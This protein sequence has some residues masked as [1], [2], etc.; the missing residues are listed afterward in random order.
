[1]VGYSS[2]YSA[3][4]QGG[5]AIQFVTHGF[6]VPIVSGT[7]LLYLTNS[8]VVFE[9]GVKTCTDLNVLRK[10]GHILHSR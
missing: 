10:A 4:S 6:Y 9:E 2:A 3:L 1:M 5:S 8:L 7:S